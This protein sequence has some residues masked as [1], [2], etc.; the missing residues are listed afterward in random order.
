MTARFIALFERPADP[1]D[2]DRHYDQV[3]IPLGRHLPGL[4]RCTVALD[5]AAVRGGEPFHLVAESEWDTADELPAAFASPE[6]RATAAD[7]ARL[8]ELAPVGSMIVQGKEDVRAPTFA[9]SRG[10]P[11]SLPASRTGGRPEGHQD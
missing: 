8:Q 6:G 11:C 1:D 3:H 2:F 7:A 9:G 10:P 4:R 5:L